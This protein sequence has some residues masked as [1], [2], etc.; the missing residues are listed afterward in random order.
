MT[1]E[2][3]FALALD[4][5]TAHVKTDKSILA[6]IVCGSLS[7]DTVWAKSDIDLALVTIDDK[8][9]ETSDIALNANGV[10]VHLFLMPRAEFRKMVEGATRNSFMHSMLAKGRLLYTHDETIRDLCGRLRDI[11]E[12]DTQLQLLTAGTHAIRSIDKAHKWFVTR[13]DLD[14]TAL[15]ILY[16]ATPLARIEVLSARLL[17]DREVILQALKL[18]PPFFTTVY[19][20]MLNTKKTHKNVRVALDAIDAYLAGR[21]TKLFGLI[22]DYLRDAGETRSASETEAHFKRNFNLEGVTTACEYLADQ[23]LIAKASL[24]VKLTK[25]SNV[26]VEELAF[27]HTGGAADGEF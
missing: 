23:G 14:Y 20:Q 24:P 11:G 1:I 4:G 22:L 13:G 25:R 6:A 3:K 9:I 21:A 26:Q 18:N 5:L 2:Q 12:R 19:T 17:A 27:V 16:A 7:H 15:W 8:K 10:N